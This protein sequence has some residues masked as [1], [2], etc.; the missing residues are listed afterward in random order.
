MN[1]VLRGR[2]KGDHGGLDD[3]LYLGPAQ[4]QDTLL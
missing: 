1:R 2:K 3:F 4:S